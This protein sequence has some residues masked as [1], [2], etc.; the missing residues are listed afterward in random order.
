MSFERILSKES[1]GSLVH[2]TGGILYGA[3]P[4]YGP[5]NRA[6]A[7]QFWSKSVNPT[8]PY[9]TFS[10]M[11]D[12]YGSS[13]LAD[14]FNVHWKTALNLQLKGEPITRF[15]MLHSDVVPEDFW[16]D[17]LL[18]ELDNT[19]ADLVSAVIPIKDGRGL[20][21]TAIDDKDDP[22]E[23]YKRL[24]MAEIDKLPDTFSSADC[25]Y[26]DRHLLVN[27]GCWVCDF[28]KPWRFKVHFEICNRLAFVTEDGTILPATDYIWGM[29][30]VFA[31]Q[32]MPEDWGFSRQLGRLGAKVL[33]TRKVKLGHAGEFLF[34]NHEGF[35]GSWTQDESL[36][37][38]FD[39][40][41]K[42]IPQVGGWLTE[43]EG[44]ALAR[45]A[46]KKAVLEVGSYLGLST[47]WM[48]RGA[49]LVMAVDTFDGRGTP[50]PKNTYNDFQANL[51]KYKVEDV[52]RPVVGES[53]YALPEVREF[54]DFAFIDGAHDQ[55]SI[56]EDLCLAER[57]L[58]PDGLLAFHD[59]GRIKEHPDVTKVVDQLI[60]DGYEKVEQVGSVIVLKHKEYVN[61]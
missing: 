28:T 47:I 20:S 21:S 51:K 34:P 53:I 33:A 44:R 50:N 41:H 6:S 23:V 5:P 12:D 11:Y 45:L 49:S 38:K 43:E 22:W 16:V 40:T 54:F 36:R 61:G 32:V 15:V 42:D 58:R 14:S 48:A 13:L 27:T 8:G 57:T 30:G 59:Y 24:T 37:R 39:D 35:W 60:R 29:P 18:E 26:Q 31:N 4:C 3:F 56:Q 9:A 1:F 19:G 46:K 2:N 17:K 25:G 7:K 10:S 55:L 52:V